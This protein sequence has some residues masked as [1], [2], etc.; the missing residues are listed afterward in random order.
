[1]SDTLI[2]T[3]RAIRHSVQDWK[4]ELDSLNKRAP[5]PMPK[6]KL[7]ALIKQV[8][9]ETPQDLASAT[10]ALQAYLSSHGTSYIEIEYAAHGFGAVRSG[11]TYRARIRAIE[12]ASLVVATQAAAQGTSVAEAMGAL[13]QAI[14]AA[15]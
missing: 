5:N 1:M 12:G 4:S 9:H 8:E 2:H 7:Q 15:Q 14:G 6:D 13:A 3:A 10:T 11:P